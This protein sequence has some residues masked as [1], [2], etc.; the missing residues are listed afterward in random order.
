MWR[1]KEREESRIASWD[2]Q[3]ELGGGLEEIA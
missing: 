2:G 1:V 3:S